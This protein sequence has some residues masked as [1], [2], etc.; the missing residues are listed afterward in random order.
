LLLPAFFT[1]FVVNVTAQEGT[2]RIPGQ[3]PPLSDE[4]PTVEAVAPRVKQ[5][6]ETSG[7]DETL[8]TKVLDAYRQALEAL[9]SAEEWSAKAAEYEKARLSAPATLEEIRGELN[10]PVT[11]AMPVIP[12]DASLEQLEQLL[13][14]AEAELK[15]LQT[16]ATNID[17]EKKRRA[18]RRLKIPEELAAA[19]QKLEEI[20][21]ESTS[22]PAADEPPELTR[23]KKVQSVARRKAA[24]H[25]IASYENEVSSYD[26]RG[27]LLTARR[28]LAA[29]RITE[30]DALVKA[31]RDVV[32][33]RRRVEA[34][35]AAHEAQRTARRDAAQSQPV[36]QSLAEENAALARERA[37][38][39]LA[40]KIEQ[41]S[42]E[43]ESFQKLRKRLEEEFKS[44]RE[45]IEIAGLTNAMGI[46]LRNRLDN[47][48]SRREYER[49]IADR[50]AELSDVQVRLIE[51]EDRRDELV[52]IEP[53]VRDALAGLD[54]GVSE[55]DRQEAAT[56]IRD[57]LESRRKYLDSL[58]NDFQAYRDKLVDLTVEET[59]LIGRIKRS[60]DYI[61]EHILWVPSAPL[62][63]MN[64]LRRTTKAL[65]W[66]FNE[67]EWRG[68]ARMLAAGLR[69]RWL[70][71]PIVL[72]VLLG[73]LFMRG[74]LVRALRE[75]GEVAARASCSTIVPTVGALILTVVL[76][77]RWPA[78]LACAAWVLAAPMDAPPFAKGVA[79][80]L[81]VVALTFVAVELF[82]QTCRPT[83][84][85]EAH[86]D[87]PARTLR[88][89]RWN[90][91]W[92]LAVRLPLLFVI[93]LADHS[94]T[95]EI[96]ASLGR[97][98]FVVSNLA[99]AVFFQRVLRP[100]TGVLRDLF[101]AAPDGW[102]DRSRFVWYPFAI[103]LPLAWAGLSIAG[104][105]YS[106]LQMSVRFQLTVGLV[107]TLSVV[108]AFLL[109][110]VLVARR[111]LALEQYRKRRA[112][113]LTEAKEAA[114]GASKEPAPAEREPEIDLSTISAQTRNLLRTAIG[115]SMILG[116][117]LAWVDVLPALNILNRVVL[118]T[119]TET[120]AETAATD[121]T[122][123]TTAATVAGRM[124]DRTVPIT[125]ADAALAVLM[126]FMTFVA[127]RNIPGLLEITI[128]QRLP[129]QPGSRYAITA[130]TRYVITLVGLV[131][132]FGAVGITWNKVQWLAAAI[133]VGL[134]FGLQEI[135]ANFVSGLILLFERPIRVGDVVTVG[136]VEGK[137]T[138][139]RMR[140]TTIL[141][142]DRREL[143]VPNKDFITGQLINWTLSDT[144]TRLIIPVGI[145]YGSD[146]ELA[147]QLLVNAARENANVLADP[148]PKALFRK[149]GNSTLDFQLLVFVA[150]PDLA[151]DVTHELLLAID[152]RF[153]EAGI[154][155]AFPQ[156]DIRIR[157]IDRPIQVL[158]Q[159]ERGRVGPVLQRGDD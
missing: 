57:L 83:G 19:K 150:N 51:L 94:G 98:A 130:L 37:E 17:D 119:T 93:V 62:P 82:R 58:I 43:L 23:A 129:L 69:S 53:T 136:G 20:N 158:G 55:S 103:A 7:V 133:T 9:K 65:Q 132:A 101:R 24:E 155:I 148:A 118:W 27:E 111:R 35:R 91:L 140:A 42:K 66:L 100:S 104:Y 13:A 142:A 48:P 123:G 152:T 47:L 84:L 139:I 154:E 112:A 121:S 32:S 87:V 74:R 45:K 33:E 156:Q 143:L 81:Y 80:A 52:D 8:R 60:E 124:V 1:F 30:T 25:E 127:L 110:W 59:E 36:V 34:E 90:I 102:V 26:A 44:V 49:K 6:K 12:A 77:L 86:F 114:E 149:L 14:Q 137:V 147:R 67:A 18:D 2:T 96:Q 134:G 151:A 50:Q 39:G 122:S 21:K 99:I 15:S 105:Y 92:L 128:L 97:W 144:T 56:A 54:P 73:L 113:A 106:A 108:Y 88:I 40:D 64:E 115:G 71:L 46:L 76:A 78:I 153:R 11:E 41:T 5:W 61:K 157:S 120:V 145:A 138:R 107:L 72:P 79:S 38:T 117:W 22:T 146:T 131:V 29:R 126:L 75:R 95:D 125:L 4:D 159:P 141:D 31:W 70:S 16:E 89:I 28:D 116:L 68:T 85:A 3:P 135:F 10:K 109:R 63:S